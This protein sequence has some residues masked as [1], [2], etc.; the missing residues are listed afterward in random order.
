MQEGDEGDL[1][2]VSK[3]GQTIRME[4]GDIPSRGRATQGVI[5]MRLNAR[6]K[7]GTMSVVMRDKEAEEAVMEAAEDLR[8]E[9]VEVLKKE[10]RKVKRAATKGKQGA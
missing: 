8:E 2:C 1:I 3:Q 6:D 9:E 10:E 7:V 4:L 5:V